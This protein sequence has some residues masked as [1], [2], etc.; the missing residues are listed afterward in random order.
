M[1]TNVEWSDRAWTVR[2]MGQPFGSEAVL[3]A[4]VVQECVHLKGF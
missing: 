3:F 4:A 1:G 2:E